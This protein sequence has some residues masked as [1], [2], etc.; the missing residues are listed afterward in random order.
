MNQHWKINFTLLTAIV[1]IVT[2][3]VLIVGTD[4]LRDLKVKDAQIN[5]LIDEVGALKGE[6]PSPSRS[7][8]MQTLSPDQFAIDSASSTGIPVAQAAENTK[9]QTVYLIVGQHSK[10]TDTIMVSVVDT[11]RKKVTL[12]SIPRDFHINGR[13]IN[14]YY[15]FFGIQKLAEQ[16]TQITNLTIDKYVI[17]DMQSFKKFVDG[18]GGIDV[19]VEKGLVD[20]LYPTEKKGYQT[21]S[22]SKGVHHMNGEL[23][24]KYA[25]SRET[26]SDFD[27]ARRQQE[28]IKAIKQTLEGKEDLIQLVGN[29]YDSIKGNIET[30]VSYIDAI[31]S[32]NAI[33][34]YS[35]STNH[36]FSTGNYL[37]STHSTGGQYILLPKVKG[38]GDMQKA[39]GDWLNE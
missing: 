21:F 10:L 35:M 11:Q 5:K 38:Y 17:V 22:I 7:A 30:N 6:S 29:I 12:F 2:I 32:F 25:R 33:R 1:S 13:K 34:G 18:I 24:L 39:I 8:A 16:I 19:N 9:A 4:I 27:R 31:M 37:Y 14:E 36:V 15:E 26:T 20:T 28:V 3:A 23:A